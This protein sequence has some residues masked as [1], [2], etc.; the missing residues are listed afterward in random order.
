MGSTG[1][2]AVIIRSQNKSDTIRCNRAV[3][4]W[5][6][7]ALNGLLSHELSH[8]ALGSK[9][10]TELQADKDVIARGLGHYLAVERAFT[11]KHSDHVL[12]EGEDRYLGYTFIRKL[13]KYQEVQQL[14]TLM[15]NIELG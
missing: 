13:L 1:T 5:P 6:E 7:P 12:R 4:N 10:H 11:N 14:D 3:R 2:N 9:M 8:L 15:S